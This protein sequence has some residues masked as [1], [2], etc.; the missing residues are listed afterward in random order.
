MSQIWLHDQPSPTGIDGL[1]A[2]LA[3]A[4]RIEP[5]AFAAAPV[6]TVTRDLDGAEV[7]SGA[8]AVTVFSDGEAPEKVAYEVEVPAQEQP[9]L[10]RARW[11]AAEGWIDTR[12]EVTGSSVVTVAQVRS[13]LSDVR[14]QASDEVIAAARDYAVERIEEVCRVS[15]RPRYCRERIEPTDRDWALLRWA[16]LQRVLTIDGETA[17]LPPSAAGK[18]TGGPWPSG[19]EVCYVHGYEEPPRVIVQA[20]ARLARHY[21]MTNP[22]DL[23][24]R[25]TGMAND[26]GAS[27]T[28]ITP[29]VHGAEF[30]VPE[31][32]AA[33]KHFRMPGGI[34]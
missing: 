7:I 1:R 24:E 27:W 32:N 6:V 25:A 13:L 20:A 16:W 18:L 21:A 28:L 8:E 22:H 34:K 11:T 3:G 14:A 23:D 4:I 2:G 19:A 17:D 5:S 15:F 30:P 29:G 9:A 12:H 26:T 10:L 31:V 33:I